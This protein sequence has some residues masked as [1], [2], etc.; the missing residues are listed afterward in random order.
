M[1]ANLFPSH[2]DCCAAVS[3]V[4][5]PFTLLTKFGLRRASGELASASSCSK[6]TGPNSNS[7]GLDT[8]FL[9]LL[10]GGVGPDERFIALI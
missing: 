2:P 9:L 1:R 4:G 6:A 5:L 3:W 7:V 10:D 8:P